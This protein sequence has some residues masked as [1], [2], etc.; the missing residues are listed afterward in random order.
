MRNRSTKTMKNSLGSFALMAAITSL[1]SLLF[2]SCHV[3]FYPRQ[4]AHRTD[5]GLQESDAIPFNCDL[6]RQ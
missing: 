1:L 2:F 3:A 4:A 5:N 6:I